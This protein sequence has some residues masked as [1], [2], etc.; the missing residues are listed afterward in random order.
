MIQ[1]RRL[2]PS[3]YCDACQITID[4][5]S[6]TR[7]N[8]TKDHLRKQDDFDEK[9]RMNNRIRR[10]ERECELRKVATPEEEIQS[11]LDE[12]DF[13]EQEKYDEKLRTASCLEVEAIKRKKAEEQERDELIDK[14]IKAEKAMREKRQQIE[15]ARIIV[16]EWEEQVR[17]MLEDNVPPH[18]GRWDAYKQK[19]PNKYTTNFTDFMS[20]VLWDDAWNYRRLISNMTVDYNCATH[21]PLYQKGT[22]F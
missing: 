2:T 22:S 8:K 6:W 19:H 4:V 15:E 11:I 10:L 21:V 14:K 5:L 3:L 1:S 12:E 7:H 18:D 16:K 17:Q 9:R 13:Q 20:F